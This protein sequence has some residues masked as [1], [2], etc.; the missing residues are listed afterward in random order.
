MSA[1]RI[2]VL[3]PTTFNLNADAA[4][5]QVLAKRMQ[6]SGVDVEVIPLDIDAMT[7]NLAVDALIV[8]SGSSSNVSA[9]DSAS[10]RVRG[11]AQD[12]LSSGTPILAVSNGFHLWGTL[13]AKDGETIAGWDLVPVHTRFGTTQHVTIGAQ[14]LTSWGTLVGVENH[15]A[16]VE[17]DG[18][19]PLGTVVHGVG[20]NVGGVD[21]IQFGSLWGSHLHGPVFAL[22][23]FF[24]DEF[25]SRVL[26]RLGMTYAPGKDLAE[27]DQLSLGTSEHLVR[28]QAPNHP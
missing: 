19:D 4:N 22:N 10:A 9:P 28:M 21:G 27:L 14:V 11:F 15:N 18:C 7:G 12:A 5:A 20:N 17:I 13:T 2:G 26:A 3:F 16:T 1:I 24:A 8:G 23:P 25:A 6:L